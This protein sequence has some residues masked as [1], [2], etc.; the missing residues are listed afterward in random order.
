MWILSACVQDW[1]QPRRRLPGEEGS[2]CVPCL[3]YGLI[4]LLE[5]EGRDLV[6]VSKMSDWL[7]VDVEL[8]DIWSWL[9]ASGGISGVLMFDA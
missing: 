2:F 4:L 6:L 7:I 1:L 5:E 3:F 9:D 8:D